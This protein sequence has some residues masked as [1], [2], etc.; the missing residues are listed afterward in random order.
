MVGLDYAVTSNVVLEA[1]YRYL[2][3]G[4]AKSNFINCV[5]S[6]GCV[7]EKHKYDLA[8]NDFRL[9]FRWLFNDVTPVEPVAY[10]APPIVRKY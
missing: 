7:A 9:G 3:M 6:N 4:E 8:S 5:N 10:P 1:S 2:N